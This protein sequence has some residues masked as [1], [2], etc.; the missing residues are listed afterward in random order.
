MKYLVFLLF[1]LAIACGGPTP[2]KVDTDSIRQ[3]A[4]QADR[5]LDRESEKH[6]E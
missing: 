5:D 3:N 4:D 1:G 6:K 2:K